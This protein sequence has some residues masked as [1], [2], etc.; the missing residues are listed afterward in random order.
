MIAQI[1]FASTGETVTPIFPTGP[2][3]MPGFLVSSVQVSPPLVDL[4]KA[5]MPVS[6]HIL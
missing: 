4:Y 5:D 2:L 1:R 3:G 6:A